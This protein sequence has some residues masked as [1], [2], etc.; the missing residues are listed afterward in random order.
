MLT[1]K[2]VVQTTFFLKSTEFDFVYNKQTHSQ[3]H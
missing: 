3:R 1:F 2:K